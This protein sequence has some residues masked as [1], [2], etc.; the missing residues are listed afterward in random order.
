MNYYNEKHNCEV[1][2]RYD[3][4]TFG[5]IHWGWCGWCVR[6]RMEGRGYDSFGKVVDFNSYFTGER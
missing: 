2:G 3:H 4:L 6:N 1:C 5:T